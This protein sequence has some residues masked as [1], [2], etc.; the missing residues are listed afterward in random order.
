MNIH[1]T[2]AQQVTQMI[3]QPYS[4]TTMKI[5]KELLGKDIN[6]IIPPIMLYNY[7]QS[8]KYR[9]AG[10]ILYRLNQ[11]THLCLDKIS[12]SHEVLS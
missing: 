12:I 2:I 9:V 1:K 10:A 7:T 8:I 6:C 3:Q 4:V 5:N 11:L